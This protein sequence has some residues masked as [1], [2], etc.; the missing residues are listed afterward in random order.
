MADPREVQ[1]QRDVIDALCANG[2]SVGQS[3]KYDRA[4]RVYTEDLVGFFQDAYPERW[5]RFSKNNPSNPEAAFVA[6]VVRELE[7][8]GSLSVLRHGFRVPGVEV[9]LAAFEPDHSMNPD[10]AARFRLNRLRVVPEL[11]YSPH[12]VEGTYNPRLD[13]VLFVNGIATATL[14]LKSEFKQAVDNA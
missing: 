9:S 11:S 13:L 5:E 1:L 7:K 2:W 12:A 4:N 14:E 10:T 6:Q 8:N 3:S